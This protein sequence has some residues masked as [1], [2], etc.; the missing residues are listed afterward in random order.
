MSLDVNKLENVVRSGGKII[1][2][3]PACKESGHDNKGNHLAVFPGGAFHCV[4]GS[5]EEGHN[6]RI[7]RLAGKKKRNRKPS[8]KFKCKW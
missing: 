6:R 1:A 5:G 7:Y 2:R 3:C 4:V 8:K